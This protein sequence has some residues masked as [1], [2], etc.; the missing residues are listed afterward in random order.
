[1]SVYPPPPAVAPSSSCSPRLLNIEF[2]LLLLLH[3]FFCAHLACFLLLL[4]LAPSPCSRAFSLSA[5]PFCHSV[6]H[7]VSIGE[8]FRFYLRSI[9]TTSS[10]SLFHLCSQFLF[11]MPSKD[12][13]SPCP[14][15]GLVPAGTTN[16]E[17]G[18]EGEGS[19]LRLQQLG[20]RPGSLVSV[21]N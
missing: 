20:M 12:A 18:T 16:R 6:L 15:R 17:G 5:F 19:V 3:F 10:L 13:K 9:A 11:E 21:V 1:M 2:F 14:C 4:F 8:I 7:L